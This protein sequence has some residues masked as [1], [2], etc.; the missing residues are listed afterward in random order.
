MCADTF[1]TL[2]MDVST[3]CVREK[4][5]VCVCVCMCL[6]VFVCVCECVCVC[7]YVFTCV[8]ADVRVCLSECVICGGLVKFV[9]CRHNK[10]YCSRQE[11]VDW[12]EKQ[13]GFVLI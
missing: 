8:R 12:L 7:V 9:T 10:F 3:V 1:S 13:T 4:V 5:C 6:F 2:V 11:E